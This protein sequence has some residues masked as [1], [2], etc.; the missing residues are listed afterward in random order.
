MISS[1]AKL[2]MFPRFSVK[3]AA[4][5]LMMA[6]ARNFVPSRAIAGSL[7]LALFYR[8]D[9]PCHWRQRHDL[10]RHGKLHQMQVYGLRRGL[11]VD[12]FYEGDNMLVIIPMSASMRCVR[13]G[14][15][16]RKPSRLTPSRVL[17]AGSS[18]NAEY[19]SV[20]PKHHDQAGSARDAKAFDGV[21]NKL[22]ELSRRSGSRRLVLT[23]LD[24]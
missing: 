1:A 12:C 6:S 2:V 13:A 14:M 16:G 4:S 23:V 8:P 19:A 5:Y 9:R 7:K 20:W 21:P 24:L 10:R 11:P 22:Q 17:K 15:P 18:C 3:P